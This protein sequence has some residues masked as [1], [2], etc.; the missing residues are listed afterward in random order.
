MVNPDIVSLFCFLQSFWSNRANS[1]P[2]SY[3]SSPWSAAGQT[4]VSP[5]FRTTIV[6]C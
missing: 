6:A 2:G 5:C 1:L 4:H 3:S